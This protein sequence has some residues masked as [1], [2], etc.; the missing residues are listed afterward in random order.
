[1]YLILQFFFFFFHSGGGGGGG[2]GGS[3]WLWCPLRPLPILWNVWPLSLWIRPPRIV[4]IY[5]YAS[6]KNIIIFIKFTVLRT[7]VQIIYAE[8][9]LSDVSIYG[10]Q[11]L[12][13]FKACGPFVLVILFHSF[14]SISIIHFLKHHRIWL[15]TIA[16]MLCDL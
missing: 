5:K 12:G 13:D 4:N 16:W 6:Y 15:S 1:M 10:L 9:T 11:F 3:E 7:W 8:V 14:I 2:D